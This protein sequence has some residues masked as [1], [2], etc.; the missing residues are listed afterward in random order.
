M[1]AITMPC[2]GRVLEEVLVALVRP[3][4]VETPG[5]RSRAAGN[6]VAHGSQ[7]D[8]IL[9]VF[10]REMCER[11]AA[12]AAGADDPDSEWRGHSQSGVS[13]TLSASPLRS[14]SAVNAS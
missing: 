4:H 8:P 1:I 7:E 9:D 14:P 2:H 12:D 11:T 13:C 5:G 6:R 3:G 10:E